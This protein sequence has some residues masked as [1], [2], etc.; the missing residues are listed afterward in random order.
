[1]GCKVLNEHVGNAIL[2]FLENKNGP[3]IER[4]LHGSDPKARYGPGIAQNSSVTHRIQSV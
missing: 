4:D 2:Q 1:M 3:I